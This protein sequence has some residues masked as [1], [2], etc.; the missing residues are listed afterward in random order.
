MVCTAEKNDG[1]QKETHAVEARDVA[2]NA[3]AV[4]QRTGDAGDRQSDDNIRVEEGAP[5]EDI[6]PTS[7]P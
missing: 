3:A 4:K 1:E 5:S 2:F 7:R 6:R